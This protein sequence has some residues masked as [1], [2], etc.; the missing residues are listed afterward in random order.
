MLKR[1][2]SVEDMVKWATDI[3]NGVGTLEKT[4][5]DY[6]D[7][8]AHSTKEDLE[9]FY[10][11]A[12]GK[13]NLIT[14]S[15]N[16]VMGYDAVEAL[17]LCWA[18]S[19]ANKIIDTELQEMNETYDKRSGEL[20]EKETAFAECRKG[21]WKRIATMQRTIDNQNAK[22]GYRERELKECRERNKVL[23]GYAHQAQDKA[24][25]LDKLKAILT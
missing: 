25:Q 16:N 19:K 17:L 7:T 5:C 22:A 9:R 8:W 1:I 14:C 24:E 4:R 10:L 20:R 6:Q 11:E 13:R 18:T 12:N 15:V 3:N 21:Y 2:E 23:I